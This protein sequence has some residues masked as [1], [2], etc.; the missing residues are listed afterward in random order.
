MSPPP[1]CVF[2]SPASAPETG[3]EHMCPYWPHGAQASMGVSAGVGAVGGRFSL[4]D[5]PQG[6]QVPVGLHHHVPL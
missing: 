1:L 3:P 5:L 4:L 2:L 6:E